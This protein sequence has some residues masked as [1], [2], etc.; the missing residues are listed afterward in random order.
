VLFNEDQT[1]N[2]VHHGELEV[3][4]GGGGVYINCVRV[5]A[6]NGSKSIKCYLLD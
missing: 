5:D 3:G 1:S 6:E 2:A 4:R